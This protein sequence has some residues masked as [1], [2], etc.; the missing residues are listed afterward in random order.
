M[1]LHALFIRKPGQVVQPIHILCDK[2]D[3]LPLRV[4]RLDKVMADIRLGVLVR[5]VGFQSSL[6]R[7]DARRFAGYEFL[8]GHRTVARPNPARASE[9]GDAG[10]RADSRAGKDDILATLSD[11]PGEFFQSHHIIYK[12]T[13]VFLTTDSSAPV[14]QGSRKSIATAEATAPI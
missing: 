11:F 14:A 3:E 1:E 6:P 13:H 9:I 12:P 8:V 2:S 10:F 7:L 5:F 4:E